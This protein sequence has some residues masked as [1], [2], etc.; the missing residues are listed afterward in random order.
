[1]EQNQGIN[2]LLML[3]GEQQVEIR[4]LREVLRKLLQ[5]QPVAATAS[6]PK[7]KDDKEAL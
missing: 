5:Q 6:E 4:A 7:D 1:M 2:D 3:I